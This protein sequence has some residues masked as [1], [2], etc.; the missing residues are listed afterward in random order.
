MKLQSV[1]ISSL[2]DF[3]RYFTFVEF[4][5]KRRIFIRDMNPEKIFYLNDR[6]KELFTIICAWLEKE[7]G[8]NNTADLQYFLDGSKKR[9]WWKEK[10]KEAVMAAEENEAMISECEL[11]LSV[12][13]RLL[14]ELVKLMKQNQ[15]RL[16]G[17]LALCELIG[18]PLRMNE[19]KLTFQEIDYSADTLF[20]PAGTKKDLPSD[21]DKMQGMICLKKIVARGTKGESLLLR[22]NGKEVAR[23]EVGECVYGTFINGQCVEILDNKMENSIYYLELRYLPTTDSTNLLVYNKLAT[24]GVPTVIEG[25]KSFAV[26]KKGYIYLLMDNEI[27]NVSDIPD[28]YNLDSF[29][30]SIP[31][32]IKSN[33]INTALVLTNTR[34]VK[35]NYFGK[36]YENVI[37]AWFERG[38]LKYKQ[39]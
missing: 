25:V 7:D 27:V 34:K 32:Y 10:K 4:W 39:L 21:S 37:S 28:T 13:D 22:L 19:L 35:T 31:L 16:I 6:Q 12:E 9:I 17:S 30:N 8:V 18:K 3:S 14:E 2:C 24:N 23:L 5:E 38:Q 29:D 1:I 20:L 11:F 33:L 26:T 15:L 36:E